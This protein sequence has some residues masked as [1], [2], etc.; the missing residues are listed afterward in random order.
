MVASIPPGVEPTVHDAGSKPQCTSRGYSASGGW[1]YGVI[2]DD[3]WLQWE[4]EGSW[5]DQQIT[6]KE[7]VPIVTACAIWGKQWEY[8]QVLF[9]CDNM[10]VVHVV[11]HNHAPPALLVL[12]SGTLQHSHQGRAS[13]RGVEHCG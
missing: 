10:A 4:W 3:Q 13:S 2:W 12:L 9:M 1:G 8:K 11:P 7:L 5:A 6:I